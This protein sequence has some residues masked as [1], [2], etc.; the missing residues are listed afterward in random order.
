M[1]GCSD[2]KWDS[3]TRRTGSWDAGG[4]QGAGRGFRAGS[5][6]ERC[7]QG[8]QERELGCRRVGCL[9]AGPGLGIWA[10]P[11][12]QAGSRAGQR[13][14]GWALG[15]RPGRGSQGGSQ[16][17][18]LLPGLD[19]SPRVPGRSP[20]TAP[21]SGARSRAAGGGLWAGLAPCPGPAG[22]QAPLKVGWAQGRPDP[23]GGAR[24]PG[25]R[26]EPQAGLGPWALEGGSCLGAGSWG[27]TPA[28]HLKRL[29]WCCRVGGCQGAH[30]AVKAASPALGRGSPAQ[31]GAGR[32]LRAGRGGAG[33]VRAYPQRRAPCLPGPHA[34]PLPGEGRG[35][36]GQHRALH[37]ALATPPGTSP[38]A[39]I[40]RSSPFPANGSFGR[41][42]LEQPLTPRDMLP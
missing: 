14:P 18:G 26:G 28:G 24:A 1:F 37:A 41:R 32:G 34:G 31:R 11:P 7:R 33:E 9:Q 3:L 6:G 23:P 19:S 25:Q 12:W 4:V 13:G 35:G 29:C 39:P 2:G 36:A 10:P 42:C 40:G 8:A 30:G 38:E 17:A 21:G 16:G 20:R 22:S 27:S 15:A 5:W